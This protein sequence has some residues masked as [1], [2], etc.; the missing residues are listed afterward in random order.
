MGYT[1]SRQDK[2]DNMKASIIAHLEAH[3]ATGIAFDGAWV[4]WIGRDGKSCYASQN[5]LYEEWKSGR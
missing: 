4:T 3:K 5:D 2:G 1:T